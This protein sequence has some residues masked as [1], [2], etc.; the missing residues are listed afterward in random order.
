MLLARN[1]D[2]MLSNTIF[3]KWF[4]DSFRFPQSG[5]HR[6]CKMLC[7]FAALYH[8]LNELLD[9]VE[10]IIVACPDHKERGGRGGG[11]FKK[12]SSCAPE[13]P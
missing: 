10:S 5:F 11:L 9:T 8:L 2:A 6:L 1:V 12:R 13:S 3:N 4:Q 7:L